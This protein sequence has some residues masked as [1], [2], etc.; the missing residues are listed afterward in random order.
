MLRHSVLFSAVALLTACGGSSS[1][2]SASAPVVTLDA[3]NLAYAAV[4]HGDGDWQKLDVA[5]VHS[6]TPTDPEG[7]LS[8][9]TICNN[10][11]YYDA[12]VYYSRV[13]ADIDITPYCQ[14]NTRAITISSGD[15][16][17]EILSYV[18]SD[19]LETSSNGNVTLNSKNDPRTLLAVGYRASDQQ[20]FLYKATELTG[21]ENDEVVTI[22]WSA[23]SEVDYNDDPTAAGFELNLAYVYPAA[24]IFRLNLAVYPLSGKSIRIPDTLRAAGDYYVEDWLFADDSSYERF[25]NEPDGGIE[26]TSVPAELSP[27]AV[28]FSQDELTVTVTYPSWSVTDL[29]PAGIDA[30]FYADGQ[31]TGAD[32]SM[33][34]YVNA[35]FGTATG[36][37][38]GL[39]QF[40]DLPELDL[41]I[42]QPS[43]SDLVTW[44]A[45]LAN[46]SEDTA[47]KRQLILTVPEV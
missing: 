34:Y 4:R 47:G 21:L 11:D 36:I 1:S 8:L 18:I 25:I 20:A 37:S 6:I 12:D 35:A 5:T 26:L 40:A 44:S 28:T 24:N 22:D 16:G 42:E 13:S 3:S 31:A 27:S 23:A 9:V 30:E 32:T 38:F 14:T 29:S 15:A 41:T 10:G 7:D 39:L 19:A 17:I 33:T 45:Q 2:D 46:Q 43:A